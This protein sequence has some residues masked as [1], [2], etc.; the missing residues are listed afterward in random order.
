MWAPNSC[1]LMPTMPRSAPAM[2][3][4]A[5]R[6][7]PIPPQPHHWQCGDRVRS[8]RRVRRSP[9][10][11]SMSVV[12][13]DP[14]GAPAESLDTGPGPLNRA[15]ICWPPLGGCPGRPW[16]SRR[17]SGAGRCR[18]ARARLSPNTA[19]IPAPGGREI[20]RHSARRPIPFA[21][22]CRRTR[23]LPSGRALH[24]PPKLRQLRPEPSGR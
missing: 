20:G 8:R 24:R 4:N 13:G 6:F 16:L 18:I 10:G 3:S 21:G 2:P 23:R 17:V 22:P 12:A 7:L 5:A 19:R 11:A 9:D 14:V 15:S 1:P